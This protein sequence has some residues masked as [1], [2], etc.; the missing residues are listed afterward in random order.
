MYA[1][2]S[3]SRT[4]LLEVFRSKRTGFL[5]TSG[6]NG[7]ASGSGGSSGYFP[8]LGNVHSSVRA[9]DHGLAVAS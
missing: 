4:V 9:L 6:V 3:F 7:F 1:V 8:S 2:Q 5:P